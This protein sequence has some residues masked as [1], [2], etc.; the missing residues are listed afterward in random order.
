MKGIRNVL[1]ALTLLAMGN[2]SAVGAD[3]VRQIQDANITGGLVAQIGA[4][5]LTLKELG[6]QFHVRMLL[7]DDTSAQ[8]AQT[9]IDRAGLQGRFTAS[10]WN[11]H[12]LP[13][14][15]R[16]LNALVLAK[17][18]SVDE[19][20]VQRVLAPRGLLITPT[21]V[22]VMPVPQ[23]IDRWTHHLYDASGN[24]V[25]KDTEVASPR[26]FRWNAPPRHFRSHNHS[27]SFTGLVKQLRLQAA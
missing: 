25:S 3:V 14:A 19:T 13:F 1:G 11:G 8:V 16:V 18:C 7:P 22:T 26:S 17:G 23:A 15:D 21:S 12:C 6:E 4:D 10:T 2:L 24:A 20:E 27:P 9:A 5:D